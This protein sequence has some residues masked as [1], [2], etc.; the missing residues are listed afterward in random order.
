LG[1]GCHFIDFA[2]WVIG[3]PV[4]QVTCSMSTERDTALALTQGFRVCLG[5]TDGS[6]A[7][8]FYTA[9]GA[10]ALGK[11]YIEAHA[12]RRT[13]VLSDFRLLRLMDGR[14]VRE[15]HSRR[16]D[17]GHVAQLRHAYQVLSSAVAES[18]PDPLGSMEVALAARRAAEYGLAASRPHH[19]DVRDTESRVAS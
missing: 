16:V 2:C 19:I 12:A 18:G 17:K 14:D 15:K 1:E 10:S 4:S 3:A 7:T 8:I 9:R 11:E 5:F 6:E 13:A